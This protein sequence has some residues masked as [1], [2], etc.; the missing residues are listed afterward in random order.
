MIRPCHQIIHYN[1]GRTYCKTREKIKAINNKIEQN[2][3]QYKLD[4]QSAEISALSSENV[5][6]Y[7]FLTDKG[8]L[9][10][11]YLLEKTAAIK[12]FEY[13]LLGSIKNLTMHLNLIKMKKTNKKQKKLY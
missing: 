3:A 1:S 5:R 7:E 13:S 6:K 12:R 8:V 10:K 4:R 2:K 9:S 11:K